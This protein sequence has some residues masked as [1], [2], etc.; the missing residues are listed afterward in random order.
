MSNVNGYKRML[1][2]KR[3]DSCN[4]KGRSEWS[5]ERRAKPGGHLSPALLSM[6]VFGLEM[7]WLSRQKPLLG[8]ET[9]FIKLPRLDR[10]VPEDISFDSVFTKKPSE[11]SW[12]FRVNSQSQARVFPSFKLIKLHSNLHIRIGVEE[13]TVMSQLS[14]A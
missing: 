12:F 13:G 14:G 10:T 11:L 1:N 8:R 7:F 3:K 9:Q 5:S 2:K 4:N 6:R